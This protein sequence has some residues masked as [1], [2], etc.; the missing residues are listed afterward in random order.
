MYR[1]KI[2]NYRK[3]E[4]LQIKDLEYRKQDYLD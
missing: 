2:Q 4:Y 3:E 1:L